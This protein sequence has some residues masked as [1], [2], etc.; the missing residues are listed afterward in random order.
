MPA[1]VVYQTNADLIASYEAMGKNPLVVADMTEKG[2]LWFKF[3]GNRPVFQLSPEGKLQVK[4]TDV[5][6]KK[7]LHRLV[8]NLLIAKANEKLTIKPLRQQT[9][10]QYPAP[11]SFK[12]YWCD[13]ES[14]YTLKEPEKP[15]TPDVRADSVLS[16]KRMYTS[17]AEESNIERANVMKAVDD[18][19]HQ[20]RFFREP[21]VNEVAL[22][23]GCFNLEPLKLGLMFSH[24]KP[25]SWE[26]A[27][28]IAERAINLA[29]WLS[30]KE[31]NELNPQ[32]IAL[33]QQAINNSSMEIIERSQSILKN[34]PELVPKVDVTGLKWPDETKAKWVEVIGYPPPEP[35]R[36]TLW[37]ASLGKSNYPLSTFCPKS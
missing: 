27:K 20:F 30:F 28:W 32:L 13:I 1:Q 11:E 34:Y 4:W 19:R 6:E 3:K 36:W 2:L 10:I 5:S 37:P 7:T 18:L 21:T 26:G 8:K 25:E 24:C 16:K 12:L 9:W 14:E 33:T 35:Q 22:K 29:S 31:K 17:R 15:T 23:S